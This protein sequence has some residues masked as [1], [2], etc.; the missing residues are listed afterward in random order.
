MTNDDEI[1]LN[2]LR[3]IDASVKNLAEGKVGE[4]INLQEINDALEKSAD[5]TEDAG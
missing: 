3:Q 5:K 1:S 4:P 2:T